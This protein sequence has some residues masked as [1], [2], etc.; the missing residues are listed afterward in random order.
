MRK[1]LFTSVF[2]VALIAQ[3]V[4]LVHDL[5]Q[6]R[7]ARAA[8]GD[9]PNCSLHFTGCDTIDDDF[10]DACTDLCETYNQGN[11]WAWDGTLCDNQGEY[12]VQHG[13]CYCCS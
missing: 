8:C 11:C 5:M 2:A 7:I 12:T 13:D 4:L 1:N 9:L 3:S 10:D 6:P